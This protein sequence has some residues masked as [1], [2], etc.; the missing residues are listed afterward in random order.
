MKRDRFDDYVRRFNAQDASAFDDYLSPAVAV[1]NGGLRLN[2]VQAMKDHYTRIWRCFDENLQVQRYVSDGASA[3][4]HLMTHFEARVDAAD[5][6]LGS[7][8]AGECFD[9]DG[10]VFYAIDGAGRF[11]EIKVAYLSFDRTGLDGVRRAVGLAH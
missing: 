10:I 4:V 8:R 9:Y 3:A 5:T 11:S 7:V 2:G 6:P 1:Q